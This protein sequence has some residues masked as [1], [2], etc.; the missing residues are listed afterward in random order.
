M[1]SHSIAYFLTRSR[2]FNMY[3]H[4]DYV[5]LQTFLCLWPDNCSPFE[6]LCDGGHERPPSKAGRKC[7][8]INCCKIT[9]ACCKNQ[10]KDSA[11]SRLL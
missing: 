7:L 9:P 1:F 10:E 5:V 2:L 3:I 11:K 4:R 8:P 6:S